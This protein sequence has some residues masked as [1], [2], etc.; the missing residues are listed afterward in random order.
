[1]VSAS[2]GYAFDSRSYTKI[3]PH[4]DRIKGKGIDHDIST[5]PISNNESAE[6]VVVGSIGSIGMSCGGEMCGGVTEV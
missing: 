6:L 5:S 4:A 1:M 2:Y 3:V